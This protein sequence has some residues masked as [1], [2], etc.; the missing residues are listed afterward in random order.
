MG[1]SQLQKIF[2]EHGKC[3]PRSCNWLKLSNTFDPVVLSES[4][5]YRTLFSEDKSIQ[6]YE[7]G[8]ELSRQEVNNQHVLILKVITGKKQCLWNVLKSTTGNQREVLCVLP[9]HQPLDVTCSMWETS[10]SEQCWR[11]CRWDSKWLCVYC[12]GKLQP[13]K[14]TILPPWCRW[15]S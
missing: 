3:T 12:T 5:L 4:V 9:P 14:A 11:V 8:S 6:R 7:T 1:K 15:K 10:K 2:A 13:A